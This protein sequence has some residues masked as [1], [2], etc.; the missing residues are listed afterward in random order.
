MRKPGRCRH[1]L[2]ICAK[3]V[4]ITD[5]AK[6][7]SDAVNTLRVFADPEEYANGFIAVKLADGTTDYT[8][9]PSKQSAVDHQSNEFHYAYL[10]LRQT[11]A[12]MPAKDA[13]IWLDVHRHVYS[14]GGRL[15]D[16]NQLIMPQGRDQMITRP[17]WQEASGYVRP[18]APGRTFKPSE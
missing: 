7:L 17:T 14:R 1:N 3:C 5:D 15:V 18:W 10:A 13:Q 6:R 4:E 8:I 16:P 12:G 9:Y 11:F 2:V